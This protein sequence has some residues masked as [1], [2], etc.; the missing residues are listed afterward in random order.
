MIRQINF[1]A[2]LDANTTFVDFVSIY[3]LSKTK[4]KTKNIFHNENDTDGNNKL[5]E[6]NEDASDA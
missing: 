5:Y 2:W 3:I 6:A 4:I 1:K